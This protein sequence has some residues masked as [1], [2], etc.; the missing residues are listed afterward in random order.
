MPSSLIVIA[1][2]PLPGRWAL[3][4][5][6]AKRFGARLFHDELPDSLDP[7]ECVVIHGDLGALEA[8]AE[9]LAL[10]ADERVLVDWMCSESEAQREIFHRWARRPLQLAE[11]ELDR[12]VGWAARAV[13]V[14]DNES[15]K[16]V[17]VGAQAPLADQVLRIVEAMR[18]RADPPVIA[19]RRLGVLVVED[20]ADQRSVL[21]D[22]LRELG[23]HVEMAP[24]AGVALALLEGDGHGI[25]LLLSDQ[26]M[27]GMTGVELAKEVSRRHPH[28]RAVLLTAH[29]DRETCD[30]ALGAHA[31]S[32]MEKP[33]S[34]VD[35]QKVIEE[36]S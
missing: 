30:G 23:C 25:D 9:M 36:L 32:V 26:R 18:P 22:V 34:V 2:P 15:E 1:G 20:D 27:P 28:I 35:L 21:A 8:R 33:V 12:Y 17:R 29:P 10:D 16:V 6:V 19:T 31:R 7:D 13:A 5:A 4:R 24:D 11:R 3:A 14:H